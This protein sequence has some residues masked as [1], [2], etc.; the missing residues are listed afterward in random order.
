M[1]AT[2]HKRRSGNPAKPPKPPTGRGMWHR[3]HRFAIVRNRRRHRA[4][5]ACR[6]PRSVRRHLD[7]RSAGVLPAALVPAGRRSGAQRVVR[8]AAD[9]GRDHARR[10]RALGR[11]CGPSLTA[12]NPRFKKLFGL[13]TVLSLL[14][15]M[16]ATDDLGGRVDVR[17]VRA[18]AG[19]RAG[20]VRDH[21]GR[22]LPRPV[23][24][25][26][27]L[28]RAAVAGHPER[29][30][31]DHLLDPADRQQTRRREHARHRVLAAAVLGGAV[32]SGLCRRACC[33]RMA[34]PGGRRA[35]RC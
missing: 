29:L 10:T 26:A 25:G 32:H 9:L 34:I 16:R 1:T 24:S 22:G 6:L 5:P 20:P 8:F 31:P 7:T 27:A 2:K 13:G 35:P 3:N 11:A 21:P 30:R 15:I 23:R 33:W 28:D 4:H 19:D 14:T 12:G 18:A 17:R